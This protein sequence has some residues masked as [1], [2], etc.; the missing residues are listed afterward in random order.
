MFTFCLATGFGKYFADSK[1]KQQCTCIRNPCSSAST[2]KPNS[3]ELYKQ[4]HSRPL[5]NRDVTYY[6]KTCLTI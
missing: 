3:V 4:I 1:E 6:N 2:A 5:R